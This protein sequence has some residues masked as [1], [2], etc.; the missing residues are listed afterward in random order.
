MRL[1]L[2]CAHCEAWGRSGTGSGRSG[3]AFA[4]FPSSRCFGFPQS[5]SWAQWRQRGLLLCPAE[6]GETIRGV[7]QARQEGMTKRGHGFIHAT[8]EG[9]GRRLEAGK[10]QAPSHCPHPGPQH[11]TPLAD[12]APRAVGPCCLLLSPAV[13]AYRA[14]APGCLLH[15]P[16]EARCH[17]SPGCTVP[18]GWRQPSPGQGKG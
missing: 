8:G 9:G 10:E 17:Q 11:A 2:P 6:K 1:G 3:D 16:R 18:R 13:F 4:P 12:A 5:S 14:A 15:T 7:S